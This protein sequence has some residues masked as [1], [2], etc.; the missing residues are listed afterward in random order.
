MRQLV[1]NPF[2]ERILLRIKTVFDWLIAQL[3]AGTTKLL[4]KLPP[5]KSTNIAEKVGRFLAPVLPRSKLARRNIALAFPE[6]SDA[7]VGEILRGVWGNV[8]RT[9]AEY[10]FLD[11]LF[12]FDVNNP[13]AGR[14]DILG[15]ENFV[16]I[17]DS[18]K[19]VIIFTGH[20]GNWEILPIAASSYDL[21][22]TAL[23]RQPNNRFIAKRIQKAR[24]TSKGHLV[25]SRAGAAWALARVLEENR[26]VGLLAD[27]AFTRGPR[28]EFFGREATANPLAAKLARQFD[29]DIYPARCIRLPG[30]R[31]RL[32]L[33]DA[34]DIPT[35]DDGAPDI[36]ETTRTINAI[37]E[38]WV[39]EYPEQWLWLHN[40]WKIKAPARKKWSR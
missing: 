21:I 2:V 12:D 32:E 3:F 5:E 18:K 13:D 20:T 4:S 23:F 29:C 7:E 33:H 28:I 30:G 27:Q 19:P 35:G 6:K 34:I 15:I 1:R 11:Q 26:A 10:V 36:I 22:V 37:I 24:R 16:K 39:R 25:P 31:F 8:A 9:I 14:I 17:R 38:G 40:R